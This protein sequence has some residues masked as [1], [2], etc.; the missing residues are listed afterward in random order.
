MWNKNKATVLVIMQ[1]PKKRYGVA[2][3]YIKSGY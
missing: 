1:D 3:F 2:E